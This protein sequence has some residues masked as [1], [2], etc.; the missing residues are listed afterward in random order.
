WTD[1]ANRPVGACSSH[2]FGK[3]SPGVSHV[4]TIGAWRAEEELEFVGRSGQRLLGAPSSFSLPIGVRTVS[5]SA[6]PKS[7]AVFHAALSSW[8]TSPGGAPPFPIP[9]IPRTAAAIRQL[10]GENP[11]SWENQDAPNR[12]TADR[13]R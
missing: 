6:Q 9:F 7:S 11:T 10:A 13:I 12:E 4:R 5:R 3:C 2:G 8:R 1:P